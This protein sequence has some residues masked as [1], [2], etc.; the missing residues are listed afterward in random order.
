MSNFNS[1]P[2]LF[3][4]SFYNIFIYKL[5]GDKMTEFKKPNNSKDGEAVTYGAFLRPYKYDI[6]DTK[7]SAIT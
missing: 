7:H 6:R 4:Q 5:K 1:L 2:N 3:K